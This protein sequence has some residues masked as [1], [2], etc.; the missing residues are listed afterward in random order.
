MGDRIC[1]THG[2]VSN[3]ALQLTSHCHPTLAPCRKLYN[4]GSWSQDSEDI[5]FL[6][7]WELKLNRKNV[8]GFDLDPS[9]WQQEHT[10]KQRKALSWDVVSGVIGAFSRLWTFGSCASVVTWWDDCSFI[11]ETLLLS[12]IFIP[13]ARCLFFP[14]K[15]RVSQSLSA[16]SS[17]TWLD[18]FSH[19]P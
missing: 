13:T 11:I 7:T 1:Q 4:P 10:G 3:G 6:L 16:C 12:L 18:A 8:S 14:N 2:G 17:H 15:P 9:D 19:L 5:C